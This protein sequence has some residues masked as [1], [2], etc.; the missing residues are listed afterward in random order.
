AAGRRANQGVGRAREF[1][2]A[3]LVGEDA[4]AGDFAGGIDGEDG[5]SMPFGDK[6]LTERLDEGALAYAGRT[7]DAEAYRVVVGVLGEQLQQL[8]SD[9]AV[10]G[11]TALD[12]REGAPE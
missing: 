6:P 3:R 5:D 1:G 9:S 4:A 2:H 8:F 11:L 12:E 7:G 10:C